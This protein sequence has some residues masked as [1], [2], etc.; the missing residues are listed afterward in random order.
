M[1]LSERSLRYYRDGELAERFSVGIGTAT[2]PTAVGTFYVWAQVPQ[3]SASGPVRGL[4][5]RPL[6]VLTRAQGLAGG[7]PHGDPRNRRTP[8]TAGRWCRTAA[9]GSTTPTWPPT[10]R[11]A[12]DA[13]PDPDLSRGPWSRT[14]FPGSTS[15]SMNASRTGR[16][17]AASVPRSA[18]RRVGS[19]RRTGR[20]RRAARGAGREPG[21]RAGADPLRAD[22]RLAVHVLPGRRADHGRRPRRDPAVR[23]RRAALRRRAPVELRRVR[24]ARAPAAVRHQRLRRDAARPVGVG[25]QAPRRELRGRRARPRVLCR[26]TGATSCSPASREY[27]RAMRPR[28]GDAHASTSGTTHIG[29]RRRARVDAASRCEEERLG[30]QEAKADGAGRREGA[31]ARQHRGCSRRLA[32][33][34][35][36]ELRIVADPPLIVPIEDLLAARR[37]SATRS[38]RGCGGW[39][40]SYRRT[41]ATDHHPHRGVP[42]RRTLARKV[43]GVGSVGTRAWIL[44][45]RRPRRATTRCSCRRRRRRRRCWSGSSAASQYANHGQRVVAGQRLMQAASDIFL[46]WQRVEGLDGETRDYYVRQLHDWKGGVD[47]ETMRVPRRDALRAGSAARPSRAR[48]PARATGSRSPPTSARATPSTGRSPT[49]PSPTPTRTS[50]TTRRSWPP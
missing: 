17:R 21:P 47:V 36:G 40:R 22:A 6:G 31:D 10:R 9:S 27:R 12:R 38:R 50:A 42:L 18:P 11:P 46:G 23:A 48:T 19:R 49:S 43:V 28:R 25:R 32:D 8:A 15:R 41:L 37:R 4:R 24:V 44:L 33:E 16:P 1:D 29:R 30:K 7:R 34:V 35:D 3:A 2:T 45:L 26:P 20:T 13:G 39:S 14:S 5:A